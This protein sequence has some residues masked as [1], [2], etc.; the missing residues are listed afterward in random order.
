MILETSPLGYDHRVM[1]HETLDLDV[2]VNVLKILDVRA[3][4]ILDESLYEKPRI[5]MIRKISANNLKTS[6]ISPKTKFE[7]MKT[8]FKRM[9]I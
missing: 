1:I 3:L 4:E 5:L 6:E 7:R 2:S 9:E 8:K